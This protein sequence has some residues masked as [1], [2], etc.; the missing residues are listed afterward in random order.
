MADTAKKTAKAAEKVEATA[1]NTA[2]A[3]SARDFVKRSADT[4]KERTDAAYESTTKF[5][6]D[7]ETTLTRMAG[8]YVSFLGGVADMAYRNVNQTI[9][10]THKL[11]EARS[12]SEAT[13]IQA[14]FVRESTQAN[15]DQLRTAFDGA[16]EM[17]SEA[18]EN[19]R[20]EASKMWN[21]DKKAA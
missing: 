6:A 21:T 13:Q 7:L 16:R 8:S 20:A 14:D 2:F 17:L 12:I 10:T 4:A 15:M 9:A 18:S 3:Q 1:A 11:A 19:V 5:N